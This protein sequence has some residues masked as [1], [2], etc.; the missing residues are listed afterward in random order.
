MHIFVS[1]TDTGV[2]KSVASAI[3]ALRL[4]RRY[5]KIVSCG[6]T[7]STWLA[8][9]IGPENILPEIYTLSL[10]LSPHQAAHADG[11]RISTAK[12]IKKL[13]DISEPLII[14]GAGG[15][16]VPLNE[17]ELMIDLI[18]QT[19]CHLVLCARSSLGTINHS[20]LSL[21]ALE[22]QAIKVLGVIMMGPENLS[23]REAIENFGHCRVLARIG[24]LASF[25]KNYLVKKSY[26]LLP[27][28]IEQWI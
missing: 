3:L 26:E 21:R 14:E 7:D 9:I 15:L 17:T 25:D 12:I 28:E 22:S 4:K 19:R 11:I 5:L 20:L 10:P 23:N 16:C 18:A 8:S 24:P 1:G 13:S 6:S 27:Q 2:G